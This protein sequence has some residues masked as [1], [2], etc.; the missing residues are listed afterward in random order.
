MTLAIIA[1]TTAEVIKLAPLMLMLQ[2]R[3][4]RYEFWNSAYHAE[5]VEDALRLWGLPGPT[6]DLIPASKQARV[7]QS[8]QVPA[9]AVR[10]AKAAVSRRREHK[11]SLADDGCPPL[12]IV[13]GDTFT[14]LL[15]ALVGRMLGARV[16]HVEAGMRSGHL[17]RPLP[18]EFNRRAVAKLATLHFAPTQV[19]AGQLRAEKAKGDVVVT[20]AN[21]ALDALRMMIADSP[22]PPVTLPSAFGLVTLHRFELLRNS[23]V[24]KDT[25]ETLV[26]CST[27]PLVMPVAPAERSRLRELGFGENS[28][29]GLH[30]IDKLSYREFLPLLLRASF[31]VT[32][33]GG[34]Q[35]ESAFLGKPCAIVRRAVEHKTG[36]G[37]SAV[38][39]HWRTEDLEIFLGD[40]ETRSR[41]DMLSKYH[42][43]EDVFAFLEA[44]G[45]V[46]AHM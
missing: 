11:T 24:L 13:H 12:V 17:L 19:E 30:V 41:P 43:T 35:Q 18:E 27:L 32:D 46:A 4:V 7:H 21:T 39:T 22:E 40:W 1:G 8:S 42:P 29:E 33:S 28:H 2:E 14:T 5:A 31:V 20:G 44:H 34:L 3:G 23:E 16:A 25:L 37:E 10:I 15:G 38:L 45:Y 6:D 9:W 26:R 36:L